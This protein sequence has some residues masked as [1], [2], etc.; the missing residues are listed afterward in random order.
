MPAPFFT[1]ISMLSATSVSERHGTNGYNGWH[2]LISWRK[3]GGGKE[4]SLPV[5]NLAQMY[6]LCDCFFFKYISALSRLEILKV[7]ENTSF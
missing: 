6:T 3:K 2:T 7:S 5:G 1:S 4:M